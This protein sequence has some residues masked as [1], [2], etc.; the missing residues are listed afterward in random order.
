VGPAEISDLLNDG[1]AS[2]SS[3]IITIELHQF[4]EQVP[5]SM[6]LPI[7]QRVQLQRLPEQSP[8]SHDTR[9]ALR[10][11]DRLLARYVVLN[12]EDL[13]FAAKWLSD[14]AHVARYHGYTVDDALQTVLQGD[15][16]R[17]QKLIDAALPHIQETQ[18]WP[19]VRRLGEILPG[20]AD[21]AAILTWALRKL[22][23]M[24]ATP[25]PLH[26]AI[27]MDCVFSARPLSRAEF[28]HLVALAS[29]NPPLQPICADACC[30]PIPDWR[31]EQSVRRASDA[32]KRAGDRSRTLQHVDQHA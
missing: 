30:C 2:Q 27:A 3:G 17:L 25:N 14:R 20:A 6:L 19:I 13:N 7:L 4:E 29:K 9:E 18:A 1:L 15:P 32:A 16:E 5:D 10:V 24:A 23:A 11:L 22:A 28:E 12:P 21:A 31:I 26:Y 8:D